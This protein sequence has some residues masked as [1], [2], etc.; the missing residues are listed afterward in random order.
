MDGERCDIYA[1]G[2]ATRE[3]EM[4]H[5]QFPQKAK[6]RARAMPQVR[7]GQRGE[8]MLSEPPGKVL[9]QVL[10]LRLYRV[11]QHAEQRHEPVERP[12]TG[13][14]GARDARMKCNC[15]VGC[16]WHDE[17]TWACFNGDSEHC[18]DFVN[19]GCPLYEVKKDDDETK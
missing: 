8:E 2:D 11:G 19:E 17:F 16:K 14:K 1:G 9:R 18:A 13:E 7:H 12:D 15:C 4:T 10:L 5:E 3:G 6:G